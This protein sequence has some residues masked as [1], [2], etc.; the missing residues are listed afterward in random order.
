MGLAPSSQSVS[1]HFWEST[2]RGWDLSFQQLLV[3]L[4]MTPTHPTKVYLMPQQT[5]GA[6][7]K[8]HGCGPNTTGTTKPQ[9]H[10][11]QTVPSPKMFWASGSWKGLCP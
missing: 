1:F 4:A 2:I 5:P 10:P 6:A 7:A 3:T 9:T 11:A 8:R